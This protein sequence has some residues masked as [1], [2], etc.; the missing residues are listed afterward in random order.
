METEILLTFLEIIIFS[1]PHIE[2]ILPIL[3]LVIGVIA[4][5]VL[6][7][8]L[9]LSGLVFM[10]IIYVWIT[11]SGDKS[12]IEP[13]KEKTNFE[14]IEESKNTEIPNSIYSPNSIKNYPPINNSDFSKYEQRELSSDP[15]IKNLNEL[16]RNPENL[17]PGDKDKLEKMREKRI[18]QLM[19]EKGKSIIDE[20]NN[21]NP[22]PLIEIQN[23]KNEVVSNNQNLI[24]KE[25]SQAKPIDTFIETMK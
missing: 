22:Q 17:N 11:F 12:S 24:K 15:T 9:G 14:Q 21:S 2:F 18:K 16:L 6:G 10:V 5:F 1:I 13:V 4:I 7:V 19:D 25:K 20:Y 23:N 3:I 8:E